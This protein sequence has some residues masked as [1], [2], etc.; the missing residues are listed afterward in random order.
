M[1]AAPGEPRS[2]FGA[3][4]VP[5]GPSVILLEFAAQGV[6]GVAPA[7]GR[8]TLRPGYNVVAADGAV[9]RRLLDALVYP[10]PRDPD[11]LPRAPGGPANA[12]MRAGLTLV[13]NDKITYRLVRDFAAGA[14]LHRFDAESRSF[15]LVA[16]DLKE[17]AAFLQ[18]T[19]GVPGAARL[20]AIL[21]ISAA[22]LPS[23]QGGGALGGAAPLAPAR[24][25]L[26]P[27]QAKRRLAALQAELERAKAA[28]KLE[29]R[30]D[31]L[32]ARAFKL[33]EQL[34]NGAKLRDGLATAEA[35]RAELDGVAAALAPLGDVEAK[36][37]A[38]EKVSAK[39][40]EAAA[41][42]AAERTVLEEAEARGRPEPL[43]R[44]P[45]FVAAAGAGVLVALAGALG[46]SAAPGLR[47]VALL[48]I[49]AFGLAA[50]SG[51][52]WIGALETW[53]RSARRRRIVDEWEQ[54]V[55]GQFEKDAA[56]VKAVMQALQMERLPELREA[57][58]RVADA[59]A[60]V[61]EWRNRLAAWEASAEAATAL[62]EKAALDAE[63]RA[64]DAKLSGEGD[65]FVRDVRSIEQEL[66][67]VESDAAAPAPA[68]PA[69]VASPRPL[70]PAGGSTEPLRA[71]LERAAA[72]LGGSPSGAGR[73][74]AQKASQA[75]SGLTFQRLSAIQ[76]DDRG[77]VQVVTGGRPA[78]AIALPAADKDLV[79]LALKLA[80]LE[81][82]LAAGKVVAVVDDAFGGLSEGGR[83]F[84]ARLLKQ[85]ARPGQLVHA[86]SDAAFREAADHTT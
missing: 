49:P 46:A 73:A 28:E 32:Q 83:R 47:Y 19:V 2:A 75:L 63:Q 69:P 21:S 72:E 52:R 62:A 65:G 76:V 29:E 60:V 26:S 86:T 50:W 20:S 48:D 33:D 18:Q 30:L 8:A 17:I 3:W 59:D 6:R 77:G 12:A 54:K 25:A 31:G 38:F 15:A 68:A 81:Q 34:R 41:K 5:S 56:E 14:Q 40:D 71:L 1:P 10:D 66:Q 9:M 36:V 84:A 67:R 11:A 70:A 7:G 35:G 55:T 74:V 53:E 44:D 27:E 23:K 85:I 64:L 37:A 16:Q 61:A 22:E 78:P 57:H 39:R 79:Y 24:T 51:L 82:G 4:A 45:G 13:G 43:W 58:G 80:F 42:V